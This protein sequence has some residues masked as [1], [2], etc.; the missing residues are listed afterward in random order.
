MNEKK[1][2]KVQIKRDSAHDPNVGTNRVRPNQPIPP[3]NN[4]TKPVRE[5]YNTPI[6]DST[7]PT[8][9]KGKDD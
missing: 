2:D 3:P 1:Q 9:E 4:P 5:S 7:S 8:P 6:K